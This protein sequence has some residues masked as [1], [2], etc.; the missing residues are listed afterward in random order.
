MRRIF[1]SVLILGLPLATLAG[2]EK[3]PPVTILLKDRHG[4][5]TPTRTSWTH[6]GGGNIDVQQ[7]TPDTVV[8]TLTAGV[9]ANEHPHGSLATFDFDLEQCFEVTFEKPGLKS[10]TLSVEM[11]VLGLLRGGSKGA[12]SESGGCATVSCGDANLVTVCVP[13]HSVVSC[14]NLAI[15]DKSGPLSA[16]IA[17]GA[18]T[19]HVRWQISATHRPALCGKAASAEFAPD[20]AL[21]TMWVGGPKD[22]FHGAVKKDFGLQV[23]L[24]TD[25]EPAPAPANG[26]NGQARLPRGSR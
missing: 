22:P 5:A 13:D 10:A 26:T 7:P 4:H 9:V 19:L 14:E 23:T 12:A 16:P 1:A 2:A 25:E 6:S 24:K 21:D 17:A 20:P 18:H 3:T 15:N 11:R 8:V